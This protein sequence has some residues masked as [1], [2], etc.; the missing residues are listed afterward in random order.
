MGFFSSFL[1]AKDSFRHSVQEHWSGVPQPTQSVKCQF[2]R[3]AL[4]TMPEQNQQPQGNEGL[5][6]KALTQ[7]AAQVCHRLET[8]EQ[9]HE[10]LLIPRADGL[11]SSP[12]E[13]LFD[14][15]S[16]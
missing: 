2:L 4:G 5:K 16:R 12:A 13:C 11:L 15:D 8:T 1:T 10:A 7:S 6:K 3:D 9:R 14:K